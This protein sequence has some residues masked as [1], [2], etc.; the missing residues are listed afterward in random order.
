MIHLNL[1]TL[2]VGS[3]LLLA[4]G[5]STM[6]AGKQ[7]EF[8]GQSPSGGIVQAYGEDLDKNP[9]IQQT[10]EQR[11]H[12]AGARPIH[13]FVQTHPAYNTTRHAEPTVYPQAAPYDGGYGGGYGAGSCPPGGYGNYPPYGHGCQNGCFQGIHHNHSYQVRRPNDLSYPPA[14]MPGGVTVYP[15][16]THKGPDCFFLG[17]KEY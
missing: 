10:S 11:L 13:D 3:L 1:M 8:R 5:C 12:D 16:Y 14:N 2:S 6:Q 7:P 9:T 4:T 15:Y 17:M